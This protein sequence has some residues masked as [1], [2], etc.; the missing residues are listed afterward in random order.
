MAPTLST[1]TAAHGFSGQPR[2]SSSV[3]RSWVRRRAEAPEDERERDDAR[4]RGGVRHR[5]DGS[6]LNGGPQR[7]SRQWHYGLPGAPRG[8]QEEGD[9][10]GKTRIEQEP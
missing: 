10:D 2:R 6:L 4:R 9:R 1:H 5:R 8:G 7:S 3:R